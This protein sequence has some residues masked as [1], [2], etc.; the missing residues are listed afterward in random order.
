[1]NKKKDRKFRLLLYPDDET[2]VKA[3]KYI[4]ENYDYACILHDSDI[5]ENG[6]IKKEHYHVVIKF[7]NPVYN[8][9]I[10]KQLG[11]KENYIQ[12]CNSI[13]Q[14][15]L[16]LIH[17]NNS[18]KFQYSIDKVEGTLKNELE[19]YVIK[20]ELLEENKIAIIMEYIDKEGYVHARELS[21]FCL[22]NQL[23]SEYRR[24]Y[25]IINDLVKEHNQMLR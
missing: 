5:T 3:L 8:T 4:K 25:S 1:M 10:I 14:S 19:K 12:D 13:K 2:H 7:D 21:K 15:L 6:E 9:S 11:I 17:Y 16:Y 24:S 22:E 18:E 20:N 23:W